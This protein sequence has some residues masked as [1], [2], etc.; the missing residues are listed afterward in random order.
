MPVSTQKVRFLVISDTHD[1]DLAQ[2][3][4]PTVDGKL[5]QFG[6]KPIPAVDVVLH[7]GDLTGAGGLENHRKALEGIAALPAELKLVIP[8]NHDLDLDY[9]YL[10]ER[11]PEL[12]PKHE[13]IKD[14]W[15]KSEI[16]LSANVKYLEEGTHG[17]KLNSGVVFTVH[18]SPY[19][20]A[21]GDSAFQY[22]AAVDRWNGA[23]DT[24]Q[25]ALNGSTEKTLIPAPIDILMTHGPPLYILDEYGSSK[26]ESAGCQYLRTAV[27]RSKP[28][29]HCFGHAHLGWGARRIKWRNAS[30]DRDKN[31]DVLPKESA[32]PNSCKKRG[33]ADLPDYITRQLNYGEQTLFVNAAVGNSN[34]SMDN[35]PWIV[36]MLFDVY[37]KGD[38]NEAKDALYM[39]TEPLVKRKR[40]NSAYQMSPLR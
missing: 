39:K 7:C 36:E 23:L 9:I 17:F 6:L 2:L 1:L 21:Y 35:T 13:E 20:P 31:L 22:V 28:R 8:G 3:C 5:N 40:A 15:T 30:D 33:Y 14:L 29:L 37:D 25:W 4:G 32:L 12:L 11:R 10:E 24:P 27:I 19:T 38:K 34:G 16:A 18:A 26:N